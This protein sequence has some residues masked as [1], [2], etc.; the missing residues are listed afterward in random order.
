[1]QPWKKAVVPGALV[2][3]VLTI[4][5]LVWHFGSLQA[6]LAARARALLDRDG[7]TWAD[8]A[9]E[10]RDLALSGTS[11]SPEA[12]EMALQSASRLFG[13]TDVVDRITVLPEATPFTWSLERSAGHL[14]M[15][16]T[17]PG[18]A[19]HRQIAS[20]LTAAF[21][22][23]TLDDQSTLARGLPAAA[24]IQATQFAAAVL[25]HLD[26]GKV[27]L[28]D[29]RLW[30]EGTA[31]SASDH[32]AAL[33]VKAPD[34]FD[35]T[36]S[37]LVPAVAV[38][39]VWR[40]AWVG[41]GLVLT[42]A[43]PSDATRAELVNHLKSIAPRISIGDTAG[44]ASG[45]PAG[46]ADIARFGLNQLLKLD[47][48]ELIIADGVLHLSGRPGSLT[49]ARDIAAALST[50]LPGPATLGQ[51]ALIPPEV[52][53]Y[54]WS[55][56]RSGTNVTIEGVVPSAEI[57][58]SLAADIASRFPGARLI[59]RSELASGAP[60]AF[61]DQAL[62][63]L[64]HLGQLEIGSVFLGDGQMSLSGQLAAPGGLEAMKTELAAPLPAGLRLGS[65]ELTPASVAPYRLSL[66][67]DGQRVEVSGHVPS[68]AAEAAITT[69]I[70]ANFPGWP[71]TRRVTLASGEPNGQAL[72][73]S[74]AASALA[75]LMSGEVIV[76]DHRIWISGEAKTIAAAKSLAGRLAA[77]PAGWSL[78]AATIEPP[79]VAD[80]SFEL[81]RQADELTFE[82]YVATDAQRRALLAAAGRI[83]PGARITDRLELAQGGPDA[84]V[85]AAEF[86]LTQLARLNAGTVR[87]DWNG[88]SLSG[89]PKDAATEEALLAPLRQGGVPGVDRIGTIALVSPVPNPYSFRLVR[90]PAG[91]AID[92]YWPS[93]S[94]RVQ[95]T[96]AI[97][98]AFGPV[99]ITDHAVL[100][101]G[102]PDMFAET[103][104]AGLSGL[105][106]L[107]E[108]SLDLAN[109]KLK[110][111]GGAA[112][113]TSLASA[114][115][116]ITGRLPKGYQLD[117]SGL[118]PLPPPPQIS[119]GQCESALREI[120]GRQPLRFDPAK[121]TLRP[122]STPQLEALAT[123][124]LR[125]VAARIFVDGHTDS[126]GDEELNLKLSDARAK[127]VVAFL[128]KAG[129]AADRLIPEGFGSSKPVASND[130]TEGKLQNRRIEFRVV[131]P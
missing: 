100:A 97:A 72:A 120:A 63:A 105:S 6:D 128:I 60:D 111:A 81:R 4:L 54:A 10:G 52:L 109:D 47:S 127:S 70:A 122:E 9:V 107:E 59:D 50:S 126:D 35:V 30:I 15:R 41:N 99:A 121:S 85:A 114:R 34:G 78:A 11:P 1:M 91:V 2:A 38:P 96:T 112:L 23:E 87:I 44:L 104:V 77:P 86:G 25:P 12:R 92:G 124:A 89:R 7:H 79:R 125:C 33:A 31:R 71:L 43:V 108:G 51:I 16:G 90:Q 49:A 119:A 17:I 13:S 14:T 74:F 28:A 93:A 39:Y 48:G 83:V 45:Q 68:T 102:A 21:A 76:A 5:S 82:G 129:I 69:D 20:A 75:E 53:P 3:I 42:G 32:V 113:E 115:D 58:A 98:E 116:S 110:V 117:A 101:A 106:R 18:E 118:V 26:S 22:S 57:R 130:T 123:A 65:L 27:T 131:E 55:A 67:S 36:R 84:L 94:A 8:V 64:A 29:R 46:Y 24:F 95:V 66:R 103:I 19:V 61:R 80:W 40:A 56:R 37:S 62:F 88:Y 73:V